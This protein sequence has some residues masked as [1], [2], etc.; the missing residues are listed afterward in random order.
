MPRKYFK[1]SSYYLDN[2]KIIQKFV[3]SLFNQFDTKDS[4]QSLFDTFQIM[5]QNSSQC[6]LFKFLFKSKYIHP[7]LWKTI[8]LKGMILFPRFLYSLLYLNVYELWWVFF[9]G[10]S[11]LLFL[12]LL[13]LF[14]LKYFLFMEKCIWKYDRNY[15][16]EEK[17]LISTGEN[18][19]AFSSKCGCYGYWILSY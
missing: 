18:K 16:G 7:R 5:W 19:Q 14:V 10:F 17:G 9:S 4:R 8:T 12:N 15:T 2:F 13:H 3:T 1:T 11:P 6:F